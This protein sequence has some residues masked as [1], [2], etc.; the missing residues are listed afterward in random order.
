M[1][2]NLL[3]TT[4]RKELN[5]ERCRQWRKNFLLFAIALVVI[6]GVL[7]GLFYVL[8]DISM[9]SEKRLLSSPAKTSQLGQFD[10][11]KTELA[12]SESQSKIVIGA[13]DQKDI[14]KL[15]DGVVRE[16]PAGVIINQINFDDGSGGRFL[17]INGL[18]SERKIALDYIAKLHRL[19]G[20]QDV[21]FPLLV[22]NTN[23]ELQLKLLLVS[24]KATEKN[25]NGN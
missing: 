6:G 10:K 16:R 2:I 20:V 25:T 8:A 1:S 13:P 11:I 4:Y 15:I 12:N 3:P 5:A 21:E 17:T 22:K 23:I 19:S 9:E 7:V 14:L 18:A 24:P